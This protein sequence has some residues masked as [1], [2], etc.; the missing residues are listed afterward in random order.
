MSPN[1]APAQPGIVPSMGEVVITRTFAAPRALVW[2]AWTDPEHMRRWWGPVGYTSPACRTDLRVG[3]RYH[4]CMRSPEGQDIWTT[5]VFREVVPT[6]RFVY[7]NSFADAD[8]NVVPATHYGM[9]ADIPLEMLVTVTLADEEGRTRMT[10]RH[11][12]LPLYMRESA[13]EGWGGSFDKLAALLAAASPTADREILITRPVRAPRDLV[14]TAFTDPRHVAQWWG[15][16]GFTLTT[17]RMDV[18]PGGTW[19]FVM[20]GLDGTDYPN[21]ITYRAVVPPERLEYDHGSDVDDDPNAFAVTVTFTERDGTT[22]I[23]MRS[24]F[25]TA[26]ARDFVV[27]RYG[28]IEGGRQTLRRLEEYL[29]SLAG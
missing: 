9:P 21:R 8:G 28:A 12:G 13:E 5:G 27:T 19:R 4:W 22:T 26:A 16:D 1:A 15:P 20:H 18:R 11:A 10:M 25:A 3:G 7:T 23:T 17:H 14:F 24:V 29:G 2:T 6:E